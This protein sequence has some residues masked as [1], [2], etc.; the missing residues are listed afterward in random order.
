MDEHFGSR[1][2]KYLD[3]MDEDVEYEWQNGRRASGN[4]EAKY[5][6]DSRMSGVTKTGGRDEDIFG[7]DLDM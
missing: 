5:D 1:D 6:R 7:N 4:N 2:Q 3:A